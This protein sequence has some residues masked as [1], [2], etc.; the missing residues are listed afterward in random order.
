MVCICVCVL[1]ALSA[2]ML[3]FTGK[4]LAW[5]SLVQAI[6]PPDTNNTKV[7]HVYPAALGAALGLPADPNTHHTAH[8]SHHDTQTTHGHTHKAHGHSKE[9]TGGD[10]AMSH[11]QGVH[12]SKSGVGG[13]WL[14]DVLGLGESPT[15]AAG[16][17]CL[18]HMESVT[19]KLL[20]CAHMLRYAHAS[21]TKRATRFLHCFDALQRDVQCC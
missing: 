9:G 12:G 18:G 14:A 5:K 3:S 8:H 16:Q 1:V 20:G 15:H 2:C 10:G 4:T 21:C 11:R 19:G 13:S 7:T 17:A 6:S